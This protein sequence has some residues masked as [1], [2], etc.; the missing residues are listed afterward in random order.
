[1][2]GRRTWMFVYLLIA[3]LPLAAHEKRNVILMLI[4]T[5]ANKVYIPEGTVLPPA[6]NGVR[7]EKAVLDVETVSRLRPGRADQGDIAVRESRALAGDARARLEARPPM[8][9]Q[10]APAERFTEIR[11]RY[12]TYAAKQRSPVESESSHRTCWDSYASDWKSG[13]QWTYYN[14]FVST[15]CAPSSGV[16]PGNAYLWEFTALGGYTDDDQWINPY[17]YV[18]DQNGNF[19]CF[20]EAVGYTAPLSCTASDTTVLLQQ[21]C[22]NDVDTGATLYVIEY[23]PGYVEYYVGWSFLIDYC[24]YFY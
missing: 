12:E 17:A 20:N 22:L 3:A 18:D 8:V 15:F 11:K 5:E 4:D 6:L 13:P 10:Y 14:D 2:P 7:A 16:T 1:M 19:E 23:G 9:F 21:G 24:T